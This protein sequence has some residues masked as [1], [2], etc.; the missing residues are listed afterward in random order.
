MKLKR[1][2]IL[3][4][5]SIKS[6]ILTFDRNF[7][8]L[9]GINESGK[10]NLLKAVSL[11]ND[12]IDFTKDDIR[13]PSHV[14]DAV[15]ESY[16]RFVFKV[17][18]SL[19]SKVFEGVKQKFLTKGLS[20]PLLDIGTKSYCLEDFCR[21]K[22]ELLYTI[23]L[24]KHTRNPSHWTIAG[25]KFRIHPEWKKVKGGAVAAAPH[26]I[27]QNGKSLNL[28][29][30]SVV[31]TRDFEKIP[32]QLLENF[33]ITSLNA[34]VGAYLVTIVSRYFPACIV[35]NYS[36]DNLLPGRIV[37]SQFI[38][39]PNICVP[40]KNMFSLAGYL[41]ATKALQDASE[42]T[43]G[44]RNI[45]RKVGE[46]TTTHMRKV[47]PE[48]KKQKVILNQNGDF[49][50]AGIEDEY[51]VYSL[52][53]RSDGFKRFFT[54]LLTI[55]A[56]NKT[57]EIHDNLIVIDEPD[58]GLHPGGIQYLREELKKIANNNIVLVSTHSIFMI[59]KEIIDRH[60]IVEKNR[61]ITEIK[62]V[63]VSNINDEEV[64]YKALGY[65][66]FELLKPKNIIF[67]GWRDKRLFETFLKS[68]KGKKLLN[69]RMLLQLGLLH[70][71]GVKDIP[72]VANTCENFSREYIIISDSD[73]IAKEKQKKFDGRGKWFCYNDIKGVEAL[74]TEDFLQ[75]SLINKA[76]RHVLKS[77][78]IKQNIG[79]D[80][81]ITHGKLN[82]IETEINKMGID[83]SFSKDLLNQI[84]EFCCLN[85]EPSDFD[86][87]YHEMS[88]FM[89]EQILQ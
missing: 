86:N 1:I 45:L 22:D 12:K 70:S 5:R 71:M 41:N 14:E 77:N 40:L 43:N 42:K 11:L 39:N 63:D 88:K 87:E 44:L 9:V 35:W 62:R 64:V 52:A 8:V 3:N 67:E 78:S 4:F 79:L 33:D 13:D 59:D 34:I 68:G 36:E 65:S 29:A 46:N 19:I 17:D 76:I 82:Y 72:R 7:Q 51:N 50:E 25:P 73:K 80:D 81:D 58:I 66:L 18:S 27:E 15:T 37:L 74:T 28:N 56:Q 57:E 10:T 20:A 75:N 47:W 26:M 2:D 85:A 84:K 16:V 89:I 60:L 31:N 24:L 48:W 49:I 38:P 61:E 54:F 69:K 30:Y 83:A 32:D 53:R 55:S 6:Q 23:D 21:Y